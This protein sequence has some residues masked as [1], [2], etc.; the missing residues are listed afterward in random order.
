MRHIASHDQTWNRIIIEHQNIKR[1]KHPD[2]SISCKKDDTHYMAY[3]NTCNKTL[4][5]WAIDD[6]RPTQVSKAE[7]S[8]F[9]Y[10]DCPFG[11]KKKRYREVI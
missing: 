6:G 11:S 7:D 9:S 2:F 5:E 10:G 1:N 8:G 3:C 4:L